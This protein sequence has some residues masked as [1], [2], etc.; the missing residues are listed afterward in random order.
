MA[1]KGWWVEAWNVRNTAAIAVGLPVS[2]GQFTKILND[3]GSGR[4]TLP[5]NF[6]LSSIIDPEN[7]VTSLLKFYVDGTYQYAIHA[8]QVTIPYAEEGNAVNDIFGRGLE[9]ALEWG[10]VYP[11]DYPANPTVS[12]LWLYGSN[13]NYLTNGDFDEGSNELGNGGAEEGSSEEGNPVDWS[14]R[15]E[16]T[17]FTTVENAT[18]A[19]TGD[20]YFRL[21]PSAVHDGFEQT[22]DIVPL[23]QY[24]FHAWVK[25]STAAGMRITGGCSVEDG[26]TIVGTND[27]FYNDEVLTELDDVAQNPLANGC[28]GGSS[29]GTWQELTVTFTAGTEQESTTVFIQADHHSGCSGGPN[30]EFWADDITFTGWGIGMDP[31]EAFSVANHN[32][33]SFQ[34]AT[35]AGPGT[36]T[37]AAT[38]DASAQ[39]AG[40]QQTVEVVPSTKYRAKAYVKMSSPAVDDTVRISILDE[41]GV[42]LAY[43]DAVPTDGVWTLYET[44]YEVSASTDKLIFRVLYVG[45]NDPPTFY[46][47]GC[48]LLAGED[49]STPGEILNDLLSPIQTRGTLSWLTTTF[50]DSLDSNSNAWSDT[51]ALTVQQGDSLLDVLNQLVGLGYEWEL[52]PASGGDTGYELSVYNSQA[53]GSGVGTDYS[54][55]GTPP[56]IV[57]GLATVAGAITKQTSAKNVVLA[58]GAEGILA[59]SSAPAGDLTAFERRE[60]YFSN[61]LGVDADIMSMLA[62]SRLTEEQLKQIGLKIDLQWIEDFRPFVD[63]VVGDNIKVNLPPYDDSNFRRV[64]AITANL[65]SEVNVNYQID[66]NRVQVDRQAAMAAALRRLLEK[67]GSENLG[68]GTGTVAGGRDDVVGAVATHTHKLAELLGRGVGGDLSGTLPNPRVV[69]IQ[70]RA[71]ASDAPDNGQ[72]LTWSDALNRWQPQNNSMVPTFVVAASDARQEI[73]DSADYTCDGTDDHLDINDAIDDIITLG[74]GRIQLSEGT[75]YLGGSVTTSGATG[76][77]NLSIVGAGVGVTTIVID[78][79]ETTVFDYFDFEPS[80][81]T[82]SFFEVAHM[83]ITDVQQTTSGTAY[84]INGASCERGWFHHLEFDS[85]KTTYQGDYTYGIYWGGGYGNFSD[86]RFGYANDA[87]DIATAFIYLGDEINFITNCHFYHSATSY[88]IQ[89]GN[90]AHLTQISNCLF[91]NTP[92]AAIYGYPGPVVTGC[93]FYQCAR[94]RVGTEVFYA[95]DSECSFV[96]NHAYSSDTAANQAFLDGGFRQIASNTIH[97]GS[98]Y[99]VRLRGLTSDA[100][101]VVVANNQIRDCAQ[102]GVYVTPYTGNR[103]ESSVLIEGNQFEDVGTGTGTYAAVYFTGGSG[104]SDPGGLYILNNTVKD[105]SEG[106]YPLDYAFYIGDYC[107]RAYIFGNVTHLSAAADLFVSSTGNTDVR[108]DFWQEFTPALTAETTSPTVV[109][110]HGAYR[111]KDPHTVEVVAEFEDFS[112][113]G[114]GVYY[115]SSL[116]YDLVSYPGTWQ[117]E[118]RIPVGKGIAYDSSATQY[119]HLMAVRHSAT[120]IKFVGEGATGFIADSVPWSWGTDDSLHA[121]V[122]YDIGQQA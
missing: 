49:A 52:V 57:P 68:L 61:N 55:S 115:L 100:G 51:L 39:F 5:A 66:M 8:D 76:A 2:S 23:K 120:Q 13:E 112:A 121:R 58:E 75:F 17:T 93:E 90:S 87:P 26:Y 74:K 64:R 63:F 44:E 91:W 116:P 54:V 92:S 77:V 32:S 94:A 12:P 71:V 104:G 78:S 102:H 25:E 70:G 40:I 111:C 7:D 45:P 85:V 88:A 96:G 60:D 122:E 107:Q 101:R 36:Q 65:E 19:R 95:Y 106:T 34:V 79:S 24:T 20:F 46:V 62:D 105:T 3:V 14:S 72:V 33:G 114:S 11:R 108:T 42:V 29:D 73:Q 119:D 6:D 38:I 50:T 28:P 16:P 56:T 18:N 22:I 118:S 41:T 31:W 37:K 97:G 53:D 1:L 80:S 110:S 81:G 82:A 83:R 99:G 27:F 113:A 86:I 4:I 89:L 67:L 35:M 84:F 47:T 43:S 98:G 48:R 9:A 109:N 117:A 10:V 15:G 21:V 69:R 30:I 59:T 103:L